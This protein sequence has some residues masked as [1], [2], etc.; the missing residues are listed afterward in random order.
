MASATPPVLGD[1]ALPVDQDE[2][3]GVHR[4]GLA[5]GGHGGD[6]A[7][8]VAAVLS[9]LE[10][11]LAAGGGHVVDSA[12]MS[13]EAAGKIGGTRW[14]QRGRLSGQ[15]DGEILRPPVMTPDR[16]SLISSGGGTASTGQRA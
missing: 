12:V 5:G 4:E 1:L 2:V 14:R 6:E 16:S 11:G 15:G 10:G 7:T 8:L 13:A 3:D 9:G